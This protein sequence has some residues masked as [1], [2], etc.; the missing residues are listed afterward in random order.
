MSINLH[1]KEWL[2]GKSNSISVWRNI[3]KT[4]E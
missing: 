1:K 4:A 3:N 2:M